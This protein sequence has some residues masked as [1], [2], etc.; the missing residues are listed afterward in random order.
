MELGL[1][2]WKFILLLLHSLL[3]QFWTR[4]HT[5]HVITFVEEAFR[6]ENVLGPDHEVDI[7][8]HLVIKAIVMYAEALEKVFATFEFI[9]MPK[10]RWD[11]WCGSHVL[12]QVGVE[13]LGTGDNKRFF[14]RR[15]LSAWFPR[16][17]L[18]LLI[19]AHLTWGFWIVN[20]HVSIIKVENQHL[21]EFKCVSYLL[22]DFCLLMVFNFNIFAALVLIKH[23]SEVDN[24]HVFFIELEN[25]SNPWEHLISFKHA[26][27]CSDEQGDS[28]LLLGFG[29]S[30]GQV[31][32][33]VDLEHVHLLLQFNFILAYEHIPHQSC[34]R[35]SLLFVVFQRI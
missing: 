35:L 23:S 24:L 5:V 11:S 25:V 12:K 29:D 18:A 15:G 16:Y 9:W 14:L 6:L 17:L 19:P 2:F 32:I 3:H 28:A 4:F 10:E 31:C 30:L 34:R 8:G 22:C 13:V 26:A 27:G 33:L 21:A 20:H 1:N 7:V